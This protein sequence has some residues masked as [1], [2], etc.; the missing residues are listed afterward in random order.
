VVGTS[1]V[2]KS[3]FARRLATSL[4]TQAIELDFLYWG[5]GWT[6]RP[7][8]R[9]AVLAAAQQP[10]WVIDGD[11][12]SVRNIVWRR[13][14]SIVWLDYSFGLAFSRVLLR[15]ARR[16]YTGERL[17]GGNRETISG[18]LFDLEAPLWRV[19]RT[20]GIRRREF[21]ELFRRAE[22]G[23]A[24]VVRLETPETAQTFLGEAKTRSEIDIGPDA[25]P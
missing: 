22:Y 17:Y 2:G 25:A 5:S 11:Y 24:R 4:R 21:P 19:V 8:F 14:T 9:E 10:R 18:A 1:C 12:P 6:P 3:T 7:D 16:V 20:H 15:T 13:C 23:H